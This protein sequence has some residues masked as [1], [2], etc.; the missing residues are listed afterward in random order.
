MTISGH[1]TRSVFDRYHIVAPSDLRDAAH[2]LDVNQRNELKVT[3]KSRALEFGHSL[4][5]FAPKLQQ[6]RKILK[7]ASPLAPLPN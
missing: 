1:K 5:T 7:Q 6:I 4:G 3:E 2:K